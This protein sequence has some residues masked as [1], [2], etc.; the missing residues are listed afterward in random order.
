MTTDLFPITAAHLPLF[1]ECRIGWYCATYSVGM[2]RLVERM[3]PLSFTVYWLNLYYLIS[4]AK[5]KTQQ[6]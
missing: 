1:A 5:K 6:H 4:K 3:K 2:R